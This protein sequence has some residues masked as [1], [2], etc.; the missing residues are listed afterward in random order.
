MRTT[1]PVSLR[2]RAKLTP[3]PPPDPVDRFGR[4]LNKPCQLWNRHLRKDG[5]AQIRV[6]ASRLRLVHRVAFALATNQDVDA[7]GEI[8]HRCR[9]RH[10]AEATH[11][12][13]V[14]HPE[15]V[16]RGDRGIGFRQAEACSKG[17]RFSDANTYRWHGRR[18]CRMCARERSRL[19][20]RQKRQHDLMHLL[21]D[22]SPRW[23]CRPP[24]TVRDRWRRRS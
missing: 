24:R 13:E 16:R 1:I 7:F 17:H 19:W 4:P 20:L 2:L 10:C 22:I 18:I 12:E 5:Y 21:R 23:A 6:D 14:T 9:V 8:D 3:A 15:N 11:L